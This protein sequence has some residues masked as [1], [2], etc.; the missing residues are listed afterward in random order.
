[1]QFLALLA[2][3][4]AGVYRAGDKGAGAHHAIVTDHRLATQN[5][6]VGIDGHIVFN[7]G[8]AALAPQALSAAGGKA[9]QGHTL[10]DL[11]IFANDRGLAN[12]DARAVVDEE[13]FTDGGAGVDVDARY[14]VGVLGHDAG[15]QRHTKAVQL[16]RQAVNGDGKKTGVGEDDLLL[17]E[18]AGS[19][20]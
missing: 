9:T 11:H 16:V 3:G 10:V 20:S 13:K 8:V 19:P 4:G 14:A 15:D 5:G 1:M 12:D 18:A 7:G 2:D 6:C 17:P